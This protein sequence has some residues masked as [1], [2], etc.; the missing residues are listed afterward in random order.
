MCLHWMSRFHHKRLSIV[1]SNSHVPS[2]LYC[3]FFP[4][5]FGL[6]VVLQRDSKPPCIKAVSHLQL[7]TRML[8]LIQGRNMCSNYDSREPFPLYSIVLVLVCNFAL[9]S[10]LHRIRTAIVNI[11]AYCCTVII[12]KTLH[13][14]WRTLTIADQKFSGFYLVVPACSWLYLLEE[15]NWPWCPV[16]WQITA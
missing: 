7:H 12:T 4:F 1:L 6:L 5:S 13:V 14:I 3:V 8:L 2:T 9:I 16:W 15:E 11:H 10:C